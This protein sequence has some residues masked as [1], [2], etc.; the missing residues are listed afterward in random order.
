MKK[1]S[2]AKRF[3]FL[4]LGSSWHYFKPH[5]WHGV[6]LSLS[7]S[8]TTHQKGSE[9]IYKSI[10]TIFP[11]KNQPTNHTHTHTH[12]QSRERLE[13]D[14]HISESQPVLLAL[15]PLHPLRQCSLQMIKQKVKQRITGLSI[16]TVSPRREACI[17]LYKLSH[18]RDMSAL[19]L[20]FMQEYR[21]DQ[22][23]DSSEVQPYHLYRHH[24]RIFW[25][26]WG[27]PLKTAFLF[28][29]CHPET[30]K[31]RRIVWKLTS[32]I[33]QNTAAKK[34][35]PLNSPEYLGISVNLR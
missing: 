15:H 16:K 26:T 9:D 29:V 1:R 21:E 30:W 34:T 22:Q 31:D 27:I 25:P 4:H 3:V 18:F 10:W 23:R 6:S 2:F 35:H 5:C 8:L 11:I 20:L 28:R 32:K 19:K 12:T 17:S 14:M 7:G 33:L 24:S 13:G